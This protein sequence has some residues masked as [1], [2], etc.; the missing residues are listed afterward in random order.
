MNENVVWKQRNV[1]PIPQEYK[2]YTRFAII[3]A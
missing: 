1:V 2:Y 3:S